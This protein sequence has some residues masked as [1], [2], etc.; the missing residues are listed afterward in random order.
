MIYIPQTVV[1]ACDINNDGFIDFEEFKNLIMEAKSTYV[2][3]LFTTY[4]LDLDGFITKVK[5]FFH[6]I[7]NQTKQISGLLIGM[8][9]IHFMQ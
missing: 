3:A 6:K 7:E 8:I 4:D 9:K 2:K 5:M 1:E